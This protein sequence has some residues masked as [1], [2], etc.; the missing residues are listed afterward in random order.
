MQP[1]RKQ[2]NLRSF[3]KW[4]VWVLLVQLI[5]MNIS[6]ALHAYKFTHFYDD[7]ALRQPYRPYKNIFVKTWKLFS[8]IKYPRSLITDV[9]QFAVDTVSL[10]TAN[11]LRIDCWYSQTDS[12]SKGTVILF[13]GLL[14]NK[15]MILPVASEFRYLGYNVLLVDL[16]GHGNSDGHSTSLGYREAEEV[17]LAYE[18]ISRRGEKTVYLWGMSLGAVIISK[19]LHDYPIQPAGVILEAPFASLQYHLKARSRVLGFPEQPFGFLVTL[20]TGIEQ[21]YNGF[22]HNTPNY[23]QSVHCP[24]LLQCGAIDRYVLPE[25]TRAIYQHIASTHKRL[26]IYDHADH[27]LLEEKDPGLWRSEVRRFLQNTQTVK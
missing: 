1:T 8:G 6:A 12:L 27:Q 5:L 26:V 2:G 16:R 13:H 3:V 19:A 4:A 14:M 25:E 24:V 11:G 18:Y 9:P 15:G 23:V 20:W 17:K 21:G 7:P 22:Q 10:H